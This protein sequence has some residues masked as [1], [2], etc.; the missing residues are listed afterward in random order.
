MQLRMLRVGINFKRLLMF[1]EVDVEESENSPLSVNKVFQSLG[2]PMPI[3][4]IIAPDPSGVEI[5]CFITGW[6]S[7]GICTAYAVLVEDSGDGRVLLV[8]GGNNGVRLRSTIESTSWDIQNPS[9][10]GEPCLMLDQTIE[11]S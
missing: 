1:I 7:E 2:I 9:Q 8:Y 6:S 10:W 3:T 11:I 4:K 5:E